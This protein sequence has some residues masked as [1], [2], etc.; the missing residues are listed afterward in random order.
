MIVIRA[1][2]PALLADEIRKVD[3]NAK[4]VIDSDLVMSKYTQGIWE[5]SRTFKNRWSL[6]ES[7]RLKKFEKQLYQKDYL[8]LFANSED[9]RFIREHYVKPSSWKG[10][11]AMLPNAVRFDAA[12]PTPPKGKSFLYFGALDS[13]PNI[14]AFVF[15]MDDVYP[16]MAE[17]L[18]KHGATLDVAGRR[19]QPI[20]H[21][22]VEK[23]S[24]SE[25]V[26]ILG[27]V[28]DMTK[29]IMDA[30]FSVFPVRNGTGTRVRVL[31]AAKAK[32]TAVTTSKG[33]EGYDMGE[34][35][36]FV[37]DDASDYAKA[38]VKLLDEPDLAARMGETLFEK[39]HHEFSEESVGDALLKSLEEWS[40]A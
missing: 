20:Y 35:A 14:D 2:A 17:A 16:H 4:V 9:D 13:K 5:N 32:R 31:D 3:P 22:L 11:T 39:A 29:T 27:E 7:W 23:H 1:A 26:R 19:V 28:D 15:L 38:V 10:N 8:F 6:L 37:R 40:G 12:A 34:D 33:A 36:L 24:A 30:S 21:E 18:A 25:H